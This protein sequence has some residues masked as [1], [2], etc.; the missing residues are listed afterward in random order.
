MES[1]AR[2]PHSIPGYPELSDVHTQCLPSACIR[3]KDCRGS[4]GSRFQDL[5]EMVKP[6]EQRP[7]INNLQRMIRLLGP[8]SWTI[9]FTI[10]TTCHR[11]WAHSQDKHACWVPRKSHPIT[12]SISQSENICLPN[13]HRSLLLSKSI[14]SV[15]GTQRSIS[16]KVHP[17]LLAM[18]WSALERW[19]RPSFPTLPGMSWVN[20]FP[21]D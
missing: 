5:S 7:G 13:D 20:F 18:T 16:A 10:T 2:P 14:Q 1:L 21:G 15:G 19:P 12:Y 17:V 4:S 8:G 11:L 9:P 3:H 6:Q